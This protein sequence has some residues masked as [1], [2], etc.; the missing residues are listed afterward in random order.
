M[1]SQEIVLD[2]K[3]FLVSETDTKGIIR[4]ANDEFCHYAGYSVEELIGKPHNTVRH[5]DMPRAAF[6]DLWATVK[7]GKKWRGFVKNSTKD[8]NYYWVFATVYPFTSCDGEPGYISC[9]RTISQ[10]EKEK[11]EKLYKEMRAKER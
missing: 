11:Y 8:G 5:P 7:S 4:F 6:K 9:R 2:K 1:A 10:E 3:A